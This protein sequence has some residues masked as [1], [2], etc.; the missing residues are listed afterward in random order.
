MNNEI[1]QIIPV[2]QADGLIILPTD[3]VWCLACNALNEKALAKMFAIRERGD[4]FT[5]LVDNYA[6]L[7]PY[8]TRI[9]PKVTAIIDYHERPLT[10]IYRNVTGLPESTL[11]EKDSVGIQITK[12]GFC[13]S[14][15]KELDAPLAIMAA[16]YSDEPCPQ[17]FSE[18][19]TKLLQAADY[20]AKYRREEIEKYDLPTMLRVKKDGE[21]VFLRK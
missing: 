4:D 20:V 17:N 1:Q 16:H 14:L 9:H 2:L 13:K 10:I 6:R 3:T 19:N 15:I 12:D 18:I 21:L 11:G 5:V 7:Q 8:V